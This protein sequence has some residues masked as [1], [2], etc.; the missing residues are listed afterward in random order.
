M[1]MRAIDGTHYVL[2]NLIFDHIVAAMLKDIDSDDFDE[3]DWQI[4]EYNLKYTYNMG[5]WIPSKS[6]LTY[7]LIPLTA[8]QEGFVKFFFRYN[9]I[10]VDVPLRRWKLGT[11]SCPF[12]N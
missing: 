9:S 12:I 6:V 1:S 2:A 7:G 4:G 11:S 8:E 3:G 10:F 5:E